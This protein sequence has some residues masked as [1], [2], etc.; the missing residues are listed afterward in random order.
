VLGW[1]R[2]ARYAA[3]ADPQVTVPGVGRAAEVDAIIEPPQGEVIER[4]FRHCGL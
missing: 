2:I 1:N 3:A 4:L